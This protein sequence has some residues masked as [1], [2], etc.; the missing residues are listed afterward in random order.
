MVTRRGEEG[1]TP[2]ERLAANMDA[3]RRYKALEASGG[4]PTVEDL[5]AFARYSGMGDSAFN[6]VFPSP[7][8][9]AKKSVDAG[10]VAL[11]EELQRLLTPEEWTALSDSRL[12]ANFTSPS[13][14]GHIWQAL[15][16]LGIENLERVHVL[17]PSAGSG[18]FL[19]LMPDQIAAKSGMTAVEL[20]SV[21]GGLLKHLYPEADVHAGVG[22]EDAPIAKGSI[23]VAISNVPFGNFK[24]TDRE[25]LDQPALTSSI[26]NYFFVKTLD[27]LRPGGVL[28]F[29]TS[30]HTLDNYAEDAIKFRTHIAQQGELLQAVRLP[31]Y[32]FPDTHVETDIIFMRKRETPISAEE[33]AREPW[34]QSNSHVVNHDDGSLVTIRRNAYYVANPDHLLGVEGAGRGQFGPNDYKLNK[35][36]DRPWDQALPQVLAKLPEDVLR[37]ADVQLPTRIDPNVGSE[38]AF[39]F[40]NG[41]L[42]VSRGGQLVEPAFHV[43]DG[44]ARV[45]ALLDLNEKGMDVL[46]LQR[47]GASDAQVQVAQGALTKAYDAFV[48]KWKPL[49]DATNR[50][51][52]GDDPRAYFLRSLEQWNEGNQRRWGRRAATEPRRRPI[53]T[54]SRATCSPSA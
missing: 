34:I 30:R 3:L 50:R 33:A 22:F 37:P 2:R 42:M 21:T 39:A 48:R 45:K 35:T 27:K 51:V 44:A 18:R 36:A 16:R 46:D 1:A 38:G 8:R 32:T 12:N 40:Q 11:G 29:I 31:R 43:K 53:S 28:A 13:I 41:K 4:D 23:D 25:Y 26:H 9:N 47:A 19:G 49:N 5:E 15:R 6:D 10:M 7:S 54:R 52:M 14:I 20:D 17:E 24:V